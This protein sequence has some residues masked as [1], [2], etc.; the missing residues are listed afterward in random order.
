ML[1]SATDEP[2]HITITNLVG[3]KVRDFISSTNKFSAVK[4][5]E[6]GGVYFVSASSAG[7]IMW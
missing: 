4:L 3:E 7:V 6:A 5:D 1:S 2:V